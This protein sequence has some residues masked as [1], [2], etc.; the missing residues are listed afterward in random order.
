LADD[1]IDI[2]RTR[3]VSIDQQLMPLGTD[4][5]IESGFEVFEVLVVGAEEGLDALFRNGNAF[6]A[7]IS[8]YYRHLDPH[9]TTAA[10]LLLRGLDEPDVQLP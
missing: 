1:A 2:L 6:N 9:Y 4:S 8:L 5:D 10:R 3:V 7:S